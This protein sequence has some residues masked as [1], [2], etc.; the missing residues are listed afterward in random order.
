MSSRQC[1]QR[2]MPKGEEQSATSDG[3]RCTFLSCFSDPSWFLVHC[4]CSVTQTLTKIH[5]QNDTDYNY[6]KSLEASDAKVAQSG[7]SVRAVER[8]GMES[9]LDSLPQASEQPCKTHVI[10]P[11][12]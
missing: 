9:N 6:V 3:G 11:T 8:T 2:E 10:S 7:R 4:I 5:P 12:L 1:G